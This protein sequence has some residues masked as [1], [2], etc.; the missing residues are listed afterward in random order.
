[1]YN[2]NNSCINDFFHERILNPTTL[3][4]VSRPQKE[5]S[6]N[7]NESR[8]YHSISATMFKEKY[9]LVKPERWDENL[10]NSPPKTTLCK[11]FIFYPYFEKNIENLD[12]KNYLYSSLETY[13]HSAYKSIFDAE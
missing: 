4:I 13:D 8:R 10:I 12:Q 3:D 9:G 2:K 7:H 1:M 6:A 11:N 5:Y